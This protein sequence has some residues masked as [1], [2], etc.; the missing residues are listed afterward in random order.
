MY[1]LCLGVFLAMSRFD[2]QL[3]DRQDFARIGFPEYFDTG[4]YSN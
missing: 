2:S 3:I 4:G 1:Y